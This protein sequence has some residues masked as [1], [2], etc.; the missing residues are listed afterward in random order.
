V[1]TKAEIGEI[2]DLVE[3]SLERIESEI[4]ERGLM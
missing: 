2:F 4:K 3:R 1:T